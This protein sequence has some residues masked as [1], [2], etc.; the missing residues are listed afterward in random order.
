MSDFQIAYDG[1]IISIIPVTTAARTWVDENVVSEPWQWLGGALCVD[2]RMRSS[3]STTSSP[4]ASKF[5]SDRSSRNSPSE[6]QG[7]ATGT[8]RADRCTAPK[9]PRYRQ[10]AVR[11]TAAVIKTRDGALPQR[12]GFDEYEQAPRG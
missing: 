5:R 8:P 3:L 4:K 2:I 9:G 6:H 10:A 11:E 7:V 12:P 1:S